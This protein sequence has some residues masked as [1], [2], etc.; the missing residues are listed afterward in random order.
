M[1]R[2]LYKCKAITIEGTTVYGYYYCFDG[3][4]Y[5]LDGSGIKHKINPYSLCRNTGVK[6]NNTYLY[7]WDL[8]E[9]SSGLS[10][11]EMGIVEWDSFNN[12]HAIR[13]S[14]NYKGRRELKGYRIN[15][16]GNIALNDGDYIKMQEYSDKQYENYKGIT[17]E[18][19]CRSTQYLNKKARQFLPK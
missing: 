16:L 11:H 8:I 5:I 1:D 12:R 17:A 6:V 4:D 10:N 2:D 19:E 7:E 15:I 13:S 18:P 9:Y 14:L 3:V